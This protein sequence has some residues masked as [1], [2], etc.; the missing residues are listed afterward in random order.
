MTLLLV[1]VKRI[2]RCVLQEH[3]GSC[4]PLDDVINGAFMCQ[5]FS[6]VFPILRLENY[7]FSVK[8]KKD[9]K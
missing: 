2:S 7:V 9:K 3:A 1:L 8:K 5:S 6:M 4:T